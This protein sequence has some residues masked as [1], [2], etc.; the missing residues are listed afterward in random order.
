MIWFGL[1]W[2]GLVWFDLIWFDLIWFDLIWDG[3]VWFG[4]VWLYDLINE[5]GF[6][7]PS[8][9]NLCSLR[10]QYLIQYLI[11][12]DANYWFIDWLL[13]YHIDWLIDCCMNL[14]I[15][16]LIDL[17]FWNWKRLILYSY[18]RLYQRLSLILNP[19]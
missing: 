2:F 7:M 6:S 9:M 14:L 16:C 4:L 19:N 5:T 1:V 12:L 3:L 13:D 17:G 11:R 18:R 10:F 8:S 15:C